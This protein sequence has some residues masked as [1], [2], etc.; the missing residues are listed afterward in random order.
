M[1]EAVRRVV[2]ELDGESI[3][4]HELQKMIAKH[5][6][7]AIKEYGT[8]SEKAHLIKLRNL[9]SIKPFVKL[10]R[11]YGYEPKEKG[12]LAG[13]TSST[14][15]GNK[16]PVMSTNIWE[17]TNVK[18]TWNALSKYPPVS[19][20]RN[21]TWNNKLFELQAEFREK[22]KTLLQELVSNPLTPERTKAVS[23]FYH[24][25]IRHG[26]KMMAQKL[27]TKVEALGGKL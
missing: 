16:S 17:K 20:T 9:S 12:P 14:G 11:E 6:T 25:L 1:K 19:E 24:E 13:N 27:K 8:S 5:Y 3:A 10:I 22:Y 2:D 21:R 4:T 18:K 15:M 26:E 7:D 23:S